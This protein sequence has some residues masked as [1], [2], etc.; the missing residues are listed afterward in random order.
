VAIGRFGPYIKHDGKFVS[1]PK[2]V[3]PQAITLEEAGKLI[4]AKR[5]AEAKKVIAT[6]PEEPELQV[7]N[8]RFGAYISFK[9]QNYKIPRGTD[10]AKLDLA[11][12]R[13]IIADPA[14]APKKASARRRTFAK[15]K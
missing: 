7:L 13:A 3:S 12:C 8:G 11:A 5:D 2:G 9:K 4:L 10:A 6:F 15:K 14:N 1:I